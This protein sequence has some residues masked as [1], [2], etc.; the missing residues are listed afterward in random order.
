MKVY[1]VIE[2]CGYDYEE[3]S[4]VI[5][6]AYSNEQAANDN[7]VD[8]IERYKQSRINGLSE[9]IEFCGEED[10]DFRGNQYSD[11]L[12]RV[13]NFTYDI[14]ALRTD[15]VDISELC[16][17]HCDYDYIWIEKWEV[18]DKFIPEDD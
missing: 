12:E 6:G 3:G 2:A 17:D 14:D 9:E 10:F 1:L 8:S 13:K 15:R 7:M 16:G 18:R 5:E 11:L 4:E